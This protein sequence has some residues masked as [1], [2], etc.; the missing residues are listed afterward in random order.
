MK[1]SN[2]LSSCA[3]V[4]AGLLSAAALCAG[5]APVWQTLPPTPHLPQGTVGRRIDID[6]ARIWYAE[7]GGRSKRA[8]VLLLHGGFGN[9][10]YFGR[11]IPALLDHGYRVV[12]MD[13]RGHGRSTRS[14]APYSYHLMAEDVIGLLDALKIRRVSVV[15]WSDGG[16]IGLDLAMNHPDR[17]NRLFAFGANADLSGA[18]DG[19]DKIRCLARICSEFRES[20]GACRRPRTNG[21]PSARPC[22]KCGRRNP[23][24]PLH[25]CARS[26]CRPR[27]PTANTTR[28]YGASTLSTWLQQSPERV[29]SSCGT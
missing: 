28:R 7:W 6:G 26:R 9:S 15:G 14:A 17:L 2:V 27:L 11:L 18:K 4:A 25:S 16:I 1:A 20:T 24:L 13:S 23:P 21:T 19:I 3:G 5:A 10:N 22:S 29:W 12:A 8:P